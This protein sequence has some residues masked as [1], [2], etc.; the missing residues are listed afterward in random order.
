VVP[1]LFLISLRS[2]LLRRV[3]RRPDLLRRAWPGGA[4][5]PALLAPEV[6]RVALSTV[7]P[8]LGEAMD[9]AW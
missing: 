4:A 8:R 7:P 9:C 1:L 5:Q 3:W 2:A 6:G